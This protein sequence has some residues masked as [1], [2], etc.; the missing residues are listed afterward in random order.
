MCVRRNGDGVACFVRSG[1]SLLPEAVTPLPIV[2]L[3]CLDMS[4]VFLCVRVNDREK[5]KGR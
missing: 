3:P 4:Y 2:L 1:V 5:E